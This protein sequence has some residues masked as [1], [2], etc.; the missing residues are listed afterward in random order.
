[1][2][3]RNDAAIAGALEAMAQ[4]IQ[5][6]PNADESAGSRS[7]ATFQRENPPVFKGTYDPD[8]ALDWLKEIERIFRVMDCT[9][10]QKVRYGTHMLAKEADDWWLETRRRL[11]AHGEEITWIAFRMEFLRKYFPEDV[12]GKKE[13][14]FLKLKQGNKSVVEYAGKFGELAKF[15]QYYDG[16][17][18]EF[19]KCIKFENGLRPE[20]KKAVS[21][22][23]IRIFVDLVDSCR[24]YEED[25]NAHYRVINEKRGKNQ[26][27]REKPYDAGKGK[28]RVAHGHKTSGGDAPARVVCFKCG[29]PGHKSDVCTADVKRCYRCGKTGH[30]SSACKHKDVVCFNCGAEGHIDSQCQKPKKTIVGGK[31]FALSGT[32]TSSEDGLV[33]GTCFINSIPLITIIDT[34][35]THCFIAADCVKRL[36]LTLSAMNGEMV[37]ELPA[38]GTVTTSLM[39]LNCPQSIFDR[40]FVVDFVCLPLVGLDVVLGMNWLKRN[41]VHIN[42]FNNTVRFSSLEEEGVGLLTGKQL[43]QLMQE[44]AQMFSLMASLSFENQVRIDE[45]KVVRE[46][47]EVFPDDIPDVPLER[48]V[49]FTI[50][51][52]PGTRPVSM[53]PYRMSAS[54]LSELKKQLEELLEK[55]FVRPS[56]SPW[57][58][59]V[60]LVKKKDGSMRLCV[61]Y[62]QLNKVTIKNKYPLPR[63]D[64]LM[65]QLVGASVF[66]KIDLRSGYHQIRVKEDDIQKTA[67]RTRYGHYEYSVMPF[68]VTNAPGVFMEYMNRIFHPYLDKFVVVFIDDIL[69]YSKN[70]EEHAEHLRTVLELLKEKQLFAKLSKCEFWLEEVSFLGHV[71]SKNGIAVDPT[72]IEAVSQW[73]AP[74][75]VSE[76]RSFLGLAGYYRKFIEG[77]SKLALPLT[78]LTRKGQAFIWDAKCEEGFQELKRRLTS[79]PI[80]ILPSPTESFVVYC[81]A[82]LMGLGGVLMQNQQ[83]VAYASRQLKVHERNYPTHDLELATVVFVLKLW[84]HYLYGSRFEVFSDH[85]SLKYLFDQKELN[86]RQRRWLEFLKDYDFG[87][88]Y[89]P[90]KANVVADALSRKTLHMSM[91]MVKELDLIE[92]FRDLSLVCEG[93]LTSVKLGMLKLTS[94]ILEEIREGQKSDVSFV[95]KLTLINQGR[96]GEFRID[97]NGIMRFGNRVCVPDVAELKKSILEEGHRSGLS[98]HPGATKMYHDLKKLFWWPGMKKDIAEFVYSCLTCQKSKIEHQKPYGTMQPLFIPEWKWD[99]IS[100][101]FVSGLHRT[102]KNC[103]AIWV[104]V[105][106][107]TKSDHFI[108]MRMDYSMERLAQLYIEKIVSLHGIPSSIVYDRDPRFTSRF[109]EGLQKA[110]GTKLRLSSAYHPQTDGQTERTIQSLE[111]LL[112]A[113]VLEKGGTW[114]SYLPLIEFTYNNSYHSSIGMAPFEALYGR[115]CRTP[116]CWFE[117]GESAVIG[118]EIVQHTT[119]KIKMI[120]E[121]MKASQSRQKSYHDKRRRTLEFQEGDH[122]FMRVTPMT[123]IGRA[124]KSRKLTP[125]FI[126]L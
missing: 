78:K 42:C 14:E 111:D 43:K 25:N 101:D 102:A 40:D 36:G 21:Y 88:N 50:D 3:G 37:V 119:E 112:R 44:E 66:S 62:R 39:C 20:I 17:N 71:I 7:L 85:K 122:V 89:H 80:L 68:G 8:G 95:D 34:G 103:E 5:N 48:E 69:I 91:L 67:F 65:D 57:G 4:A 61:D 64:D 45:L 81:D 108:P 2:A 10:T 97:E 72:K 105:D 9:P 74:K 55:K 18:G 70:E 33:R 41:Y 113:C 106:R 13:I 98:I 115:R 110:L 28:Q 76:I 49:E 56:V 1:M 121:K 51:L 96:G 120:Q 124:L 60:L 24:I 12:R 52:V 116:L 15:Y 99:N 79:A 23:K 73:E 77:F 123:G 26:Q 11:E 109:W 84:R 125:R 58:A 87:L 63:I 16:A 75:S 104:V 47:S 59:P 6:Q 82:S 32:Q 53:A 117:S 46:F 27:S 86:M 83:V 114:D 30:M 38:K 54:E 118:P 100:M 29:R 93:T 90:G 94:G 35:A 92:Q 31:V 107:L 19:S 126:G 22:Q